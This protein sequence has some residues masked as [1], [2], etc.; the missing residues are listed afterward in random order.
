MTICHRCLSISKLILEVL[1][2][3]IFFEFRSIN[4]DYFPSF[5]VKSTTFEAHVQSHRGI[6]SYV[7]N[8][9]WK[10]WM[11]TKRSSFLSNVDGKI[12]YLL[13]GPTTHIVIINQDVITT[14]PGR[15]VLKK[16]TRI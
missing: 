10:V 16:I 2:D 12:E 8:F 1:L 15:V 4:L 9:F 14:L 7:D 13:W 5:I 3:R 11:L 6:R